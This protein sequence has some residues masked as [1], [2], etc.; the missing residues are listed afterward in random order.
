MYE[1]SQAFRTAME[2]GAVQHISGTLTLLSGQTITLDDSNLIGEPVFESQ[3]VEDQEVFAFGQVYAGKLTI[4]LRDIGQSENNIL[5]GSISLKF[6]VEGFTSGNSEE[7]V[8]LGVWDIKEA[9]KV[10][11]Q[12]ISITAMDR[13]DRLN[14]AMDSSEAGVVPM[15]LAMQRVT[16]LTGVEFEQDIDDLQEFISYPLLSVNGY[17]FGYAETCIDEVRMI[18]KTIGG[19]AFANRSGKIE[20]RQFGNYFYIGN[21]RV[22]RPVL[23]IPASKRFS[24]K[25][26]E[27]YCYIRSLTYTN[28][29]GI[30]ATWISDN[31]GSTLLDLSYSKTRYIW[32]SKVDGAAQ[33]YISDILKAVSPAFAD[34]SWKPGRCEWYGDPTL[35]LGDQVYLG[36]SSGGVVPTTG[37]P[38]FLITDM[39][40]RFRGRQTLGSA[41]SGSAASSSGGGG[42]GST[43]S[44]SVNVTNNI[45]LSVNRVDL[46]GYT[47]E[48]FAS[49]RTAADGRFS[50]RNETTVF[51]DVTMLLQGTADI[52]AASALYIDGIAQS[53]RPKV[54]LHEDEYATLHY[55][56]PTIVKGG[57][58]SLAA[59]IAGPCEL[60]DVQCFVWGQELTAEAPDPTADS[61]YTYT[62]ANGKTTVTGYIGSSKYPKIPSVLGGGVTT[63]LGAESFEESTIESVYI[64]DGVTA[65]E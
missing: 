64:P 26:S 4:D 1:V 10:T 53:L 49:E 31:E 28:N 2:S 6:S 24:L 58:H 19:I 15:S 34:L 45:T 35:D 20:F 63:T 47:G 37:T 17:G 12:R 7:W 52:T 44:S 39:T 9:D 30:S 25:L 36:G 62:V 41:G 33:E 42:S 59:A 51:V 55:T 18:A 23:T 43:S 27:H 48:V 11:G 65:I 56:L 50:C 61:D 46:T 40:W 57:K 29:Y 38:I 5:G 22:Y 54:T 14:V 16:E 32:N 21:Q 13:I 60:I 3:C 8:P